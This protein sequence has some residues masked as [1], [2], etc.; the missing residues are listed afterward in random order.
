MRATAG[1][2]GGQ[3][4]TGNFLY[5]AAGLR[6][7]QVQCGGPPRGRE[8]HVPL[9]LGL[10]VSAALEAPAAAAAPDNLTAARREAA[11]LN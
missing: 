5:V 9:S 4:R 10:P 1:V 11:A 7:V 3:G 6:G 2:S 8:D